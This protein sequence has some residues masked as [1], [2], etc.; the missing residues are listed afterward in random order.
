MTTCAVEQDT[1]SDVCRC[2]GARAIATVDA[3]ITISSI[4]TVPARSDEG[5]A[6]ASI[7]S[8]LTPPAV[9]SATIAAHSIEHRSAIDNVYGTDISPIHASGNSGNVECA[10]AAVATP[11]VRTT[12]VSQIVNGT[13]IA[14]GATVYRCICNQAP[15]KV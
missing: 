11:R 13:R 10:N 2:D 6:E 3:I 4:L 15:G 14:N 9:D 7:N 8:I 1:I 5:E 12:V